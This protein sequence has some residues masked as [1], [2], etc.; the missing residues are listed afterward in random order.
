MRPRRLL[1]VVM[2]AA[3]AAA[4]IAGGAMA[5]SGRSS[6][7]SSGST[8]LPVKKMEKA[9]HSKG[10]VVQGDL[11]F[12]IDRNDIKGVHIGKTPIKP[13]FEING[14][15][16]F[17]PIGKGKAFMN[18]DLALKQSETNRFISALLKNG[19]TFQAFHQHMYDFQ[20]IVFFI[21]LRGTGTPVSLAKRAYE[22]INEATSTPFPQAP[23]AHPKTSLNPKRLE[24]ML[25]GFNVSVGSDGV[26]TVLV[27]RRNK[28]T[29]DGI[30][31]RYATNIMTNISFE[32]LTKKGTKAAVIPDIGMTANEI[33]KVIST[34]RGMNWDIGCLYNQETDEHPQLFFS[35]MFKVG[36]PYKLAS[37]IQKGISKTN[38]P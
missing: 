20:P 14:T 17:Q 5:A 22:T 4:I 38:T 23:P 15:F 3:L 37:E 21:H 7:T 32:P 1:T 12:E 36:N 26:V 29:I 28:E 33:N 11:S 25:H 27:A 19:F 31:V 18:A 6:S 13:S 9:M 10:S 34:M 16:A 2:G 8:S 24:H 35:H 30:N